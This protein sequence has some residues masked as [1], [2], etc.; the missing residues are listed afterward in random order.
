MY[1]SLL[2]MMSM[3]SSFVFM[4]YLTSCVEPEIT[5]IVDHDPSRPV[6]VRSFAPDSGRVATQMLISGENF[7]GN[8]D[9][10]A[11]FINNKK[12]AVIGV[13]PEGTLIYCIVPSLRGDE[14]REEGDIIDASVKILVGN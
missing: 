4:L 2:W 11:V 3:V 10:I 12:A 8:K 13:N 14:F 7:G 9:S 1:K 6:T 5:K